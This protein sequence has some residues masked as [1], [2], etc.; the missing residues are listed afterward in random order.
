LSFL[1]IV[2]AELSKN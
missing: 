2:Q 1:Y